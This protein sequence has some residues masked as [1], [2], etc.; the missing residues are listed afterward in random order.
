MF[1]EKE[2]LGKT[3]SKV[4]LKSRLVLPAF[5]HAEPGDELVLVSDFEGISIYEK[6]YFLESRLKMFKDAME[7]S[8]NLK[9]IKELR[10]QM[11]LV[12]T[13]I[14]K[15]MVCDKDRR[16]VLANGFDEEIRVVGCGD[17]VKLKRIV[18]KNG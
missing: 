12:Y 3:T 17:H 4:S 11:E 16:V 15:T 14:I 8:T 6:D 7:R 1:G 2:I 5:T 10:I 9:E 18:K 13:K